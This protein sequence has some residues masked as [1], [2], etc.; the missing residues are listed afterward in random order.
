MLLSGN[1]QHNEH[2][3]RELSRDNNPSLLAMPKQHTANFQFCFVFKEGSIPRVHNSLV[4]YFLLISFSCSHCPWGSRTPRPPHPHKAWL[5]LKFHRPEQGQSG[6]IS[7][8]RCDW[9]QCCYYQVGRQKHSILGAELFLHAN[10]IDEHNTLEHLSWLLLNSFTIS[11]LKVT[12]LIWKHDHQIAY[13]RCGVFLQ[14]IGVVQNEMLLLI[15][16]VL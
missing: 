2:G 12:S 10:C 8:N 11:Y 4:V 5:A 16:C 15:L 9:P 3:H 13:K 6:A 14:K 1:K 7:S